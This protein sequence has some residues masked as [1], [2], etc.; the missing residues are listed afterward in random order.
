MRCLVSGCSLCTNL[1]PVPDGQSP[2]LNSLRDPNYSPPPSI[3]LTA[4]VLAV[5]ALLRPASPSADPTRATSRY[6]QHSSSHARSRSQSRSRSRSPTPSNFKPSRALSP[7]RLIVGLSPLSVSSV[8]CLPS[9][10]ST[11]EFV[12]RSII[13][14]QCIVLPS[15]PGAASTGDPDTQAGQEA[16]ENR[17]GNGT[18]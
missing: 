6:S 5:T 1:Q 8:Q 15:H 14:K 13:R 12:S 3:P 7:S 11:S 4:H 18:I 16:E 9:S 2:A 10:E 17:E